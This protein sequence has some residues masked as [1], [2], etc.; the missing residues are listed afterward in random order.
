[1]AKQIIQEW[2]QESLYLFNNI[3]KDLL[4]KYKGLTQSA[5]SLIEKKYSDYITLLEC[6][7]FNLAATD[8][9][10]LSSKTRAIHIK[11]YLRKYC[12]SGKVPI[13]PIQKEI[14]N[15]WN[16]YKEY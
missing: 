8:W 12:L 9:I 13:D 5:L 2:Y 6:D 4:L 15:M 7:E 14:F 3:N 10:N 16:E 11:D 1:M